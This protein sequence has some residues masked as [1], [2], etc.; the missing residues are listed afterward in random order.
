MTTLLQTISHNETDSQEVELFGSAVGPGIYLGMENEEYHAQK[1]A[2]SNSGLGDIA[3][4]PFHYWSKH[5]NPD[6]PPEKDKAGQLE[7]T[8]AHCAILEPDEFGKRYVVLP[9][10]APRRPTSAQLN[11]KKPSDDT[12]AAIDW[13]QEWTD[14]TGGALT[15]TRE[16]YDAAMWQAEQ[17]RL[18]PVVGEAL[19]R[20]RAEVSAF[21]EDPKTGVMCRCR[22]DFVHDLSDS[23]VI[24]FDVKTYSDANPEEFVLQIARKGYYRQ[25][26]MYSTGYAEATDVDVNG[27][28]FLAVESNYPYAASA[29]MLD[30]DSKVAGYKEYRRCLDLYAECLLSNRWPS[31]CAQGVESVRLPSYKLLK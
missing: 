25:D 28:I 11:A 15:I 12:L 1:H 22:P 13:W 4:S 17:V 30:D 26:A 9:E 23:A 6:R 31:Y 8:L 19:G 27:F 24:L 16:Q 18:L 20:G 14:K 7:G 2:I 3:Q 10:N 21:W 29:V 5:L